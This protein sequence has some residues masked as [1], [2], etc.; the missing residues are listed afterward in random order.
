MGDQ[1]ELEPGTSAR[2]YKIALIPCEHC[3][4]GML[5]HGARFIREACDLVRQSTTL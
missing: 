2:L 5:S 3:G 4:K 1:F